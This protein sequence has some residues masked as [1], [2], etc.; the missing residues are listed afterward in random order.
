MV[1]PELQ[2]ELQHTAECILA[3]RVHL[4]MTREQVIAS[5]GH[6]GNKI[7][8][9][10]GDWGVHEQWIYGEHYHTYYYFENG[11]LTSWQD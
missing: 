9:S 3:G 4:G 5:I 8:R 6:H 1:S 7:N 2:P 11:I 10:V